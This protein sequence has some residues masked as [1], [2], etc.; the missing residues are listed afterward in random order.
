M[1]AWFVVLN[2]FAFVVA[3]V[4]F[5]WLSEVLRVPVCGVGVIPGN[6]VFVVLWLLPICVLLLL[7]V[8]WSV[9]S[10]VFVILCVFWFRV[11]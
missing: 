6:V 10:V 2:W 8:W 5:I 11:F 9:R 7:G 4:C 1:F 3:L